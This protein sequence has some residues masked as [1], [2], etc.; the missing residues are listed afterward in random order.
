MTARSLLLIHVSGKM[1]IIN[2]TPMIIK[3]SNYHIITLPHLQ[4]PLPGIIGLFAFILKI[5]QLMR[6]IINV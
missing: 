5:I 2:Q 3:L 1:K 4:K 6:S